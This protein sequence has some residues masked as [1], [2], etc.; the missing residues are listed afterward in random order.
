L[1]VGALG[2]LQTAEI[3]TV[4][5]GKDSVRTVEYREG[6]GTL[7][8]AGKKLPVTP[9]ITTVYN[10][11]KDKPISGIRMNAYMSLPAGALGLAAVPADELIDIRVGMS[12]TTQ[13]EPPPKK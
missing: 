2:P 1:R 6:Q 8:F 4:D 9:R 5:K 11:S 7:E 10:T 12:G 3:K 13:T